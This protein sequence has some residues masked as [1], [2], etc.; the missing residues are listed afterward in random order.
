MDEIKKKRISTRDKLEEMKKLIKLTEK[1][2]IVDT[3]EEEKDK[4]MAIN[5][6]FGFI[7]GITQKSIDLMQSI[8][9]PIDSERKMIVEKQ[10]II[11]NSLNDLYKSIE[12]I[13]KE[14]NNGNEEY[15]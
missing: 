3:D 9:D 11:F 13:S 2:E 5:M 12:V 14:R 4:K 15:E 7:K 8:E 10:S 6:M 1:E